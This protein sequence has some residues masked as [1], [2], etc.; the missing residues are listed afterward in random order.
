MRERVGIRLVEPLERLPQERR[1]RPQVR[2]AGPGEDALQ[3]DAWARAL[4]QGRERGARVVVGHAR[5]EL[6]EAARCVPI[7][8]EVPVRFVSVDEERVALRYLPL[9]VGHQLSEP[10]MLGLHPERRARCLEAMR[11]PRV[12]AHREPGGRGE[13]HDD[14][15]GLHAHSKRRAV[16]SR[17]GRVRS[18]APQRGERA[19]REAH[20]DHGGVD[21]DDVDEVGSRKGRERD[22][23]RD[24]GGG[25]EASERGAAMRRYSGAAR[26]RLLA[27]RSAV[28]C[29][30]PQRPDPEP[31]AG[32]EHERNR[33][34]E[35]ARQQL[36]GEESRATH[37]WVETSA[38]EHE[39]EDELRQVERAV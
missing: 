21:R 3:D 15:E 24:P 25:E 22:R 37:L 11:E 16:R 38:I 10:G 5:I 33:G 31:G 6:G 2:H 34:V 32:A 23:E 28:P 14:R 9:D 1:R 35:H 4:D 27:A 7:G 19:Q 39:L 36:C 26:R 20:E 30:R 18:A 12:V 29:A 13:Q 8:Q 17:H